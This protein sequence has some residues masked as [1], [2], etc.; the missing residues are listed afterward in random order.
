MYNDYKFTYAN[1]DKTSFEKELGKRGE[2]YGNVVIWTTLFSLPLFI[3][4]DYLFCKDL[5]IDFMMIR[6]IGAG[7]AYTYLTTMPNKIIGII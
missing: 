5:W 7:A 1:I 4:I 3:L 6:L 2:Y